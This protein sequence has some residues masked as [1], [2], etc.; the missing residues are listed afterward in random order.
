MIEVVKKRDVLPEN[1]LTFAPFEEG[2]IEVGKERDTKRARED[3]RVH[4]DVIQRKSFDVV[5]RH[6]NVVLRQRRIRQDFALDP[7][8]LLEAGGGEEG[9]GG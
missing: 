2:V 4:D 3:H 1:V 5:Q 8:V 6:S 9:G 7:V